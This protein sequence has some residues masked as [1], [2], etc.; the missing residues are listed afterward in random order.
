[1]Q[2]ITGLM[3]TQVDNDATPWRPAAQTPGGRAAKL[4][5]HLR[6]RLLQLALGVACP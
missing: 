1:M 6:L 2:R 3:D 5:T 4:G